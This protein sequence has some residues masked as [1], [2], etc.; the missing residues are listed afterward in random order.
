MK[1]ED[2]L[3]R[4]VAAYLRLALAAPTVWT[5]I[6]AG[7]GGRVRGAQLK[8]KGLHRGWPD[9]IVLHPSPTVGGPIVLGLELKA[10]G[11]RISP[12]QKA[13]MSAFAACNAWYV[14]CRSVEEV[15][16]ACRYVGIPLQASIARAA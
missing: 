15:E 8:A 7:G 10:K 5:T 14:L 6:P 9:L 11:G 2:A 3:H 1:S 13:V 4:A 16:R 12:D